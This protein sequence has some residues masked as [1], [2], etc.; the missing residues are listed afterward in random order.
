[1]EQEELNKVINKLVNTMK[2][3][4]AVKIVTSYEKNTN[5]RDYIKI[6]FVMDDD[7]PR[8]EVITDW[9]SKHLLLPWLRQIK[10]ALYTYLALEPIVYSYSAIS[11][12]DYKKNN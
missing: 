6:L 3:D 9:A 12:K 4:G 11:E 1:M 2:P 5:E 8:T 7:N 10:F